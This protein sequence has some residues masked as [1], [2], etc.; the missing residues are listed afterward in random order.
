MGEDYEDED[1]EIDNV[2]W[3]IGDVVELAIVFE[4][5]GAVDAAGRDDG[6]AIGS[7]VR[8]VAWVGVGGGSPVQVCREV[9]GTS[10]LMSV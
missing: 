7:A 3:K 10:L 4:T 6:L 9:E 2:C 1:G 8:H 5:L